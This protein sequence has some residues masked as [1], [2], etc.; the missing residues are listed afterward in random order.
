MSIVL[1]SLNLFRELSGTIGR[2]R[3]SSVTVGN[4][5]YLSDVFGNYRRA[6]I[7]LTEG[8]LE[9]ELVVPGLLHVLFHRGGDSFG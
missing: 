7:K 6:L 2:C 3:Q 9:V 4:Y 8:S 5:R 1:R